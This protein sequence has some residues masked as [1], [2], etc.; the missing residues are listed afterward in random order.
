VVEASC[1]PPIGWR[2][3]PPEHNNRYEQRIWVSPSGLTAYGI[4]RIQL[5][6]PVGPDIILWG[7]VN[8]LR[9]R[10]G[11]GIILRKSDDAKLPG[12]RAVVE[13][14]KY[15]IRINLVTQSWDAWAVYAGTLRASPVNEGELRLAEA[16]R[17]HTVVGSVAQ[18]TAAR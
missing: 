14:G 11:Q 2:L 10:E 5:P 16:A 17:E 4:T 6:W 13:G 8:E 9:R 3:K 1:D 12:L 15:R 7:Y 18:E